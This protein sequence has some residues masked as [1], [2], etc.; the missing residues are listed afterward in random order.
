[1]TIDRNG[2]YTNDKCTCLIPK[3]EV[4][5]SLEFFL[6]VLNSKLLWYYLRTRSSEYAGGYFAYTST[7]LKPFPIPVGQ[8]TNVEVAIELA[9]KTQ[10]DLTK[11]HQLMST[12]FVNFLSSKVGL[13]RTSKNLENW[14]GLEFK[15][16][17]AELKKAKVSLTLAEEAEWLT[18]FTAE[19]AKAQALQAQIA[20]T[21]KEIDA[22]VYQLYGLTEEEIAVVEGK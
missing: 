18:Y 13:T 22:L 2:Y 9:V 4:S 20:K 19:K 11:R 3:P 6:G 12:L 10:L 17:L 7:Y 5:Q 1:M 8:H 21:D 14:P 16:F 15:G